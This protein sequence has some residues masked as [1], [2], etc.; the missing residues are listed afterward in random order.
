HPG[1][2]LHDAIADIANR[3]NR[4]FSPGFKHSVIDLSDQGL[5]MKCTRVAHPP[6]ALDQYLWLRK[7]FFR[8]VHPQSESVS[9]VVVR[10]EFLTAKV[11]SIWHLLF[12][13]S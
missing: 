8:P 11:L 6:R 5:K 4:R 3:E 12:S 2:C 7:I 10:S 1:G 9:L 13:A